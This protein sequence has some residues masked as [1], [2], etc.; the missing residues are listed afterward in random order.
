MQLTAITPDELDEIISS[1]TENS[2]SMDKLDK[3]SDAIVA[4]LKA[5]PRANEALAGAVLHIVTNG[6]DHVSCGLMQC[7]GPFMLIAMKLVE[8]RQRAQKE[9]DELNKLA[10]DSGQWRDW[11]KPGDVE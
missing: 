9:L 7:V 4:A 8:Q 11:L 10:P 3:E 2:E 5:S 6:P 1:L